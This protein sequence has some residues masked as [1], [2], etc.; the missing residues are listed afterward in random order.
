MRTHNWTADLGAEPA[1]YERDAID[2]MLDAGSA[3][4]WITPTA[5]AVRNLVEDGASF[6]LRTADWHD[7]KWELQR[8]R[9][10]W[11]G[12][13]LHWQDDAY[14]TT[15]SVHTDD[16]ATVRNL[17]GYRPTGGRLKAFFI[18]AVLAILAGT[19]TL[20]AIALTGGGL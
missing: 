2:V 14:W 6:C 12:E 9:I 15:F 10:S 3:F 4:D 19:V 16:A 7:L 8:R 11:W 1:R 17:T 20:L 13:A 18:V 5:E